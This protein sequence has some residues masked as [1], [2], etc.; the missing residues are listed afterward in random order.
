MAKGDCEHNPKNDLNKLK[1]NGGEHKYEFVKRY[2]RLL[3]EQ[4]AFVRLMCCGRAFHSNH[5]ADWYGQFKHVFKIFLNSR[6]ARFGRH[7]P[8]CGRPCQ[9][10]FSNPIFN[11]ESATHDTTRTLPL[12]KGD[13]K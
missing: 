9:A 3:F 5:L 7:C 13:Q 8:G 2:C 12:E 10:N 4:E 6:F 1:E 11:V